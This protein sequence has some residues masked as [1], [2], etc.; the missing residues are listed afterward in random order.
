MGAGGR[1]V[2]IQQALEV[3]V[4]NPHIL[5]DLCVNWLL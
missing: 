1:M 4:I 5:L 3:I 2:V